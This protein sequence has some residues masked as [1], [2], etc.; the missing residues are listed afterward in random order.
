[1]ALS[2]YTYCS[3]AYKFSPDDSAKSLFIGANVE[4]EEGE[5]ENSRR[6]WLSI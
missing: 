1:M 2:A 5:S 6:A 4:V 3:V